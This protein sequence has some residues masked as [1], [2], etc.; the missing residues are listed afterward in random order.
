MS[1]NTKRTT[2]LLLALLLGLGS[3]SSCQKGE[4]ETKQTG[5]E[6]ETP[7][8]LTNVYRGT[9]LP[10]PPTD[11]AG[12]E[13]SLEGTNI[14][15]QD[16]VITA[17]CTS[18]SY[19]EETQESHTY[20]ALYHVGED[21][22]N[23]SL[24]PLNLTSG[25]EGEEEASYSLY[26]ASL[27]EDRIVFLD[28]SYDNATDTQTYTLCSYSFAD[29]TLTKIENVNSLFSAGQGNW[30][31]VDS[32]FADP[33]GYFYLNAQDSILVLN[34]DGTKAF[35]CTPTLNYIASMG[36][37]KDG[38]VYCAGSDT[39][40][41]GTN[42]YCLIPLDKTAKAAG[43]AIPLPK[44]VNPS[45]IL[46][47]GDESVAYDL[48]YSNNDGIFGF[49]FG[50]EEGELIVSWP[51]SDYNVDDLQNMQ[52]L[53][54]ETFYVDYYNWSEGRSRNHYKVILHHAEDID[55]SAITVVNVATR[56]NDQTLRQLT[57]NFNR[58]HDDARVVVT[59][60]SSYDTLENNYTGGE[61]KLGNDLLNGVIHPDL[62]VLSNATGSLMSA[63]L[64]NNLYADLYSFMESDEEVKKDDILG[65]VKNTF[66]VD[67][68]LSALPRTLSI[69]TILA[70][71]SVVGDKTSWTI[72]E[73]LDFAENLPEGTTLANNLTQK[74]APYLLLGLNSY[75]AF[76]N[77]EDNT[78]HFTDPTFI[79]YLNYLKTL[80]TAEMNE[81][82]N[83]TIVYGNDR[84]EYEGY[85]TGTMFL[86]RQNYA[87]I[88]DVS[89]D[90]VPFNR[91]ETVRIGYPAPEGQNG[92]LVNPNGPL[93][94][95]TANAAAPE[96]AWEFLK[97]ALFYQTAFWD[98]SSLSPLRS[99]CLNVPE[100]ERLRM[101]YFNFDGG[102]SSW[103][104]NSEEEIAKE[105]E[106]LD[107]H[108]YRNGQPGILASFDEERLKSFVDWLDTIGA[109]VCETVSTE[110]TDIINEEVSSFLGGVRDAAA[111]ADIIQ[112]RVSI[113]LAEH[114]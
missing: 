34:P 47:G 113:W 99:K 25:E 29:E 28:S 106:E 41:S 26:N 105:F 19:D 3:L 96:E 60:Y 109:P 36:V 71:K 8:V 61:T 13:Y 54:P 38:T 67:G 102:W 108:G 22:S 58:T 32:A 35:E 56:S 40:G 14:L 27:T 16:G 7:Q 52:V 112:S 37:G 43:T 111:T 95:L 65:C 72:D 80:P 12:N 103:G 66:E 45:N 84:N 82:N 68:K 23:P 55:L 15:Y 5:E 50:T 70:P 104:V 17:L 100:S 39:T 11:E 46:Y 88:L 114:S 78:C 90:V 59:D 73:L 49:T 87:E 62:I 21:G 33:E 107:E 2:A 75:S 93:F 94:I 9:N 48:Y 92:S 44:N 30:F 6:A 83:A 97:S 20:Y 57:V 74:S 69:S 63:I 89:S 4:G 51:N 91:A 76:V 86:Y 18:Y 42:S 10:D 85:Q 81:A 110:V 53:G 24:E 79:R 77:F 31:Y 101:V 1:K 98:V 64:E